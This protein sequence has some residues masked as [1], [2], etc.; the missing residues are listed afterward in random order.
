MMPDKY[1]KKDIMKR[2]IVYMENAL[3]SHYFVIVYL[4]ICLRC[5][6]S[7]WSEHV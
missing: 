1:T 3:Y 4:I 6:R 7:E 5:K 2:F